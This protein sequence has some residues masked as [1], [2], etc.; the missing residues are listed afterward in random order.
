MQNEVPT[1]RMPTGGAAGEAGETRRMGSAAGEY[2]RRIPGADET[3]VLH[4]A[5]PVLAFLVVK[6]GPRVGR[7]YNLNPEVTTMGRDPQNDI[8]LDDEAVSRQHAKVRSEKVKVEGE[9]AHEQFFIYDL[10]TSNGTK[11]NGQE[12]MKHPLVDG[13][14]IEIGRTILVFKKV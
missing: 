7:V 10:A 8:I 13:D 14:E 6:S 1:R 2:E 12:I 9:E 5:P 4:K 11:V 3:V